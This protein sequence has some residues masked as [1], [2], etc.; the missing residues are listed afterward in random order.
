[1]RLLDATMI[2]LH[3]FYGSAIP[4]YAILFHRWEGESGFPDLYLAETPI[5]EP[6]F[7]HHQWRDVV[8]YTIVFLKDVLLDPPTTAKLMENAYPYKR[9]YTS[10]GLSNSSPLLDIVRE[11]H[12]RHRMAA[13]SCERLRGSRPNSHGRD[14]L[15]H[16]GAAGVASKRHM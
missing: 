6:H 4:S 5:S 9:A 3:E 11:P 10:A 13:L 1:M 2:E 12:S 7:P 15:D 16:S 8:Q 14:G